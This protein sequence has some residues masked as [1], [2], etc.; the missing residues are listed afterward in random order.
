M[1]EIIS[2]YFILDGKVKFN[3]QS[4][5]FCLFG[6]LIYYIFY[7]NNLNSLQSF[8]NLIYLEALLIIISPIIFYLISELRINKTPKIV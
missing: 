6:I 7:S 4:N 8:S 5:L 1:T 2:V 3:L